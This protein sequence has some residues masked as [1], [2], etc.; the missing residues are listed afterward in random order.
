MYIPHVFDVGGLA[1]PGEEA[2]QV[3][4][5]EYVDEDGKRTFEVATRVDAGDVWGIPVSES[6][7]TRS[8]S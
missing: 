2:F 3:L 6:E 7:V 1:A 8:A 4:V 5:S